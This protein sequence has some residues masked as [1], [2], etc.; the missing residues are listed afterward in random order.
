MP[1]RVIGSHSGLSMG[2][3]GTSHHALEDIGM[4]RSV[5][6]LTVVN[7]TD[8]NHLRAVLRASV[9]H[10]GAMYIRGRGRDPV[11]HEDVPV[12]FSFG[13]AARLREGADLTII[14]CG[15]EVKPSLDAAE[16]LTREGF[17]VRVV[18]MHTNDLL[19]CEP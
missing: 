15:A 11:V 13:K 16:T 8:A 9:D 14:A 5:A 19:F 18:D 10:P 1:V 4:M 7:A 2:F 17:S 3:Y 6:D 12:D